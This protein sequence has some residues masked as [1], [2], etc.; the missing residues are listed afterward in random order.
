MDT[1]ADA[2]AP[3]AA[4]TLR[5]CGSLVHEP[6]CPLAAHHT[7]ADR[8]GDEVRLRILFAAEPEDEGEIRRHIDE[9]LTAGQ[10][11]GTDGIVTF[12]QLRHSAAATIAPGEFEHARR[13]AN[14][15]Q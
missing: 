4:I 9:A 2:R 1:H 10:Q 14:T 3:G 5:L 7:R 13:L 8:V 11:P 6:P 15:A 12:W